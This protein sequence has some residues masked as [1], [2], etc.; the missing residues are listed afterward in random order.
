LDLDDIKTKFVSKLIPMEGSSLP[1]GLACL[2]FAWFFAPSIWWVLPFAFFVVS[3]ASLQN[4]FAGLNGWTAGAGF[5]ASAATAIALK[6]TVLFAPALVL[7]AAIL[8]FLLWNKYPS[9]VLEG[10]SGTLLIGAGIAGLIVLSG[11][12][13]LVLFGLLL[14]LPNIVDFFFLK[15][16]TNRKDMSQSKARPYL[17]LEDGRLDVPD[18]GKAKLDF[19]KLVLKVF[20]PLREWQI[21][22]VIWIVCGL[23]ALLWLKAFGFL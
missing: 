20:G 15:L 21:V 18:G 14:Y 6:N 2:G 5:I 13:T 3:L 17:L 12:K 8:G 7:S 1:I 10:D 11:S 23:N 22:L 19:A 4:T 16:I 9:R